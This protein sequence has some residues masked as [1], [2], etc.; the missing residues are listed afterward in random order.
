MTTSRK[1]LLESA[2][3]I[4]PT[5]GNSHWLQSNKRIIHGS[6]PASWTLSTDS[7]F[8]IQFAYCLTN[9]GVRWRE[10]SDLALAIAWLVRVGIAEVNGA[11]IRKSQ[12]PI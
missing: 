11:L 9:L 10:Q 6:L 12:K 1:A 4:R 5:L 8:R 3:R 2:A 7:N